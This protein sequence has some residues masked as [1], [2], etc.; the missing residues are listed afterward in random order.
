[1]ECGR[2]R[3]AGSLVLFFNIQSAVVSYQFEHARGRAV[4]QHPS[5]HLHAGAFASTATAV[6]GAAREMDQRNGGSV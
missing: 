1:M 4:D 6:S 5:D 2:Q 3:C